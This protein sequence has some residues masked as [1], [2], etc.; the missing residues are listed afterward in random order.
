M[1][2]SQKVSIYTISRELGLS[3]GTVSRALRDH[4]SI[5]AETR[6]AVKPLAEKYHF[7]PRYVS[8]KPLNICMLI[9][10]V[11]G[12]PLGFDDHVALL[13]E[14]VAEYCQEETLEMSIY[15][16][17]AE[18][19]N[20]C[21]IVRELRRRQADGAIVL[22][23]T[24]QSRYLEQFEK[25]KFPYICLTP[26]ASA[27][28]GLANIF[29]YE[30]MGYMATRHLLEQGHRRIGLLCDSMHLPTV[31]A[32]HTGYLRALQ[33]FSVTPEDRFIFTREPDASDF[34]NVMKLGELG[35]DQLLEKS[36][37][38]TG[39]VA[40]DDKIAYGAMTRL[41]L[42]KIAVPDHISVVGISDYPTS[43]FIFPPLTTIRVPY[44]E[45]GYEMARQ[46][47]RLCRS[48]DL[49]TKD[50]VMKRLEPQLVVRQST[51]QTA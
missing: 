41:Q 51:R 2:K 19:M 27:N 21:D 40:I 38:M 15:G 23:T 10:K 25:F 13:L 39:V 3:P 8:I 11:Q 18:E 22:R 45:I 34:M 17:S 31:K 14:G 37:D 46:L 35:I 50:D 36:P 32:R 12:H 28:A 26:D 5:S 48:M 1:P 7:K 29:D 24:D 43:E 44:K 42:R 6:A 33:E 49:L 4:P 30:R 20:R 16:N 9:Q 47:H